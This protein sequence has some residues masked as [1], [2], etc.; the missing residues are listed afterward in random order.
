M[1][2]TTRPD[3]IGRTT[4]EYSS[5]TYSVRSVT[6]LRK[7]Y[8]YPIAAAV[9]IQYN[10]TVVTSDGTITG[11][12]YKNTIQRYI[13]PFQL[14]LLFTFC[15]QWLFLDYSISNFYFL[16]KHTLIYLLLTNIVIQF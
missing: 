2:V 6:N 11:R 8:R 4:N 16:I 3:L 15:V 13:S 5:T 14:F 1:A 12:V 7:S 9:S 10:L